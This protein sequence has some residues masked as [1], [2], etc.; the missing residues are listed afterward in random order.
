M[1]AHAFGA[2][3]MAAIISGKGRMSDIQV[4]RFSICTSSAFRCFYIA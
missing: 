1:L 2:E 3:N 4:A